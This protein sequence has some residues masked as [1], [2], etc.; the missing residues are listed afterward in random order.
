MKNILYYVV[1]PVTLCLIVDKIVQLLIK[2]Y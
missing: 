2:I 1:L